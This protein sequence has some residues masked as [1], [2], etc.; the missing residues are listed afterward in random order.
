MWYA[1]GCAM[2]ANLA[3]AGIDSMLSHGSRQTV[4]S[5]LM[6]FLSICIQLLWLLV[7]PGK[8]VKHYKNDRV[9]VQ[10]SPLS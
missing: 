3:N 8:Q 6:A 2:L 1:Y 5:K 7:A 10:Q 9:L 4:S